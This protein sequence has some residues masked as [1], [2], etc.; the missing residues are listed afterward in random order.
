MLKY[1][2]IILGVW[3][4]LSGTVLLNAQESIGLVSGNYAGINGALLNPASLVNF[5]QYLDIQLAAGSVS[6]EN[7]YLYFPAA[8]YRSRD[9]FSLHPIIG[10]FSQHIKGSDKQASLSA[11]ASGPGFLLVTG[12]FA[13]G[14]SAAAR[15]MV[16]FNKVPE[17]M[18]N[19]AYFGLNYPP[20][21][22]VLFT[23]DD[24]YGSGMAWNEYAFSLARIFDDRFYNRISA[25]ITVKYNQAHSGFYFYG[26]NATYTMLDEETLDITNMNAVSA[27]SLPLDY[28]SNAFPDP[29]AFFK[30]SGLSLDLGITLLRKDKNY[31]RRDFRRLCQ[32]HYTS[33]LYKVGFS[34]LDL[35]FVRFTENAMAH[36]YPEVD[37]LWEQ[38][39]AYQFNDIH[40]LMRDLSDRFYSDASKSYTGNRFTLFTPAAVSVQGDVAFDYQLYLHALWIH[41]LM[42]GIS[43]MHRPAQFALVPRYEQRNFE[44]ALP[45]SLYQYKYP[46]I[47]LSIRWYALTLGT[48]K[49][50]AFTGLTDFS[51][52]DFYF[53]LKF[54]FDKG[55]CLGSGRK[56]GCE[57][58]RFK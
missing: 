34:I 20:Q 36:Q 48:E 56:Y 29:G 31:H 10:D 3:L 11:R 2:A 16:S 55:K 17:S 51:G 30:G 52:M 25:G 12:D 8:E 13:Y 46:R 45:V 6:F 9:L 57:N 26:Q 28:N 43:S 50:G 15:T 54:S 1:K 39:H 35:G 37:Y 32:Q 44:V 4:A 14:F 19:F 18:A 38:I 21:L 5:K 41:P 53:S 33:Y 49:I 23:E 47:G 40:F 58:V 22:G 7:D 27:M 42:M 24:F